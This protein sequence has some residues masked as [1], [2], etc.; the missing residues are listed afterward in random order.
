M[1]NEER[2]QKILEAVASRGRVLSS[3]LVQDL[4]VSEDTIRRDLKD[5]ADAGLVTRVHGGALP[6][7][8]V[9]FSYT[10]R[11][12]RLSERKKQLRGGRRHRC[13]TGK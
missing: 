8:K 5:L 1:L 4:K 10:K 7:S 2:K 6:V 3:Q 11:Q 13:M 12:T 9:S